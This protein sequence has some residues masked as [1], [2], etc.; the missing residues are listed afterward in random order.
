MASSARNSPYGQFCPVA[1]AA[2]ILGERWT[3]LVVRE[4]LL[5][6]TRYGELQK[7]LAKASPT[8][9]AKRL[10]ELEQAGVIERVRGPGMRYAEYRLTRAGR[11]LGAVIETMGTWA[12]RWAVGQLGRDELDEY[13]LMLDISRRLRRERIPGGTATLGF[14]FRAGQGEP[15]WWIVA[16]PERAEI[17]DADPGYPL[18]LQ[19]S[20]TLRQFIEVWLGRRALPEAIA[21]GR[22]RISGKPQLE[23]TLPNWLGF[24]AF[25]QAAGTA[26]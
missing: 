26:P 7:A 6:T 5:G 4:L 22:L 14:R 12:A 18:D 1:K 11:E 21:A 15:D 16:D 24:S 9:L 17:C 8:I 25:A 19:V 20:G 10:K 3:L 2:A 23:R 13:F